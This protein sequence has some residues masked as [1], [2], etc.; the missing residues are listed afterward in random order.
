LRPTSL[1]RLRGVDL[2]MGKERGKGKGNRER[3]ISQPK[4]LQT[5]SDEG[6]I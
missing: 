1:G 3:E 5:V 4:R 2:K 6:R